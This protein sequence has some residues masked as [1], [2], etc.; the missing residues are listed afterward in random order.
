MKTIITIIA[1]IGSSISY[2]QND[3]IKQTKVELFPSQHGEKKWKVLI[4]LDARRSF[5]AGTKIKINGLRLGA[6]Y[7]GVHRFGFGFYWL[8][9]NVIFNEAV[10]NQP[11]QDLADPEVRFDLGY[12][13]IF[14]ERVFLKTRWWEVDIPIHLGGGEI[15][16]RFKDTLGAYQQ[17]TK[18]PFSALVPSVQVKFYPFT[19]L[20][21]RTS[22][23]YRFTMSQTNEVKRTFRNAFYG[24]GLSLNIL[25][26]YRAV[27]KK[28]KNQ[29]KIESD[30]VR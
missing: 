21:I 11:T 25:G 12:S 1:I 4:G 3:S 27:F 19:W 15:T 8:N 24:Y 20:A 6:E 2:S 30:E 9:K 14:Y 22:G 18:A 10:S 17:F 28:E 26:L 29:D 23:G 7:K 13:S 16:G 5:F